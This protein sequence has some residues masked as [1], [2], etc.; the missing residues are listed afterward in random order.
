MTSDTYA[1]PETYPERAEL[2]RDLKA[3]ARQ[4]LGRSSENQEWELVDRSPLRTIHVLYSMADGS[5]VD[6]P[7]YM[8][9]DALNRRLSTGG[10]A[11]TSRRDRAPAYL[12]G[13]TLCFKHPDAAE[14]TI[15][16][17]LGILSDCNAS[18]LRNDNS[19]RIHA[20]NR[21][22]QSWRALQDHLTRQRE[23]EQ[24]EQQRL[25]VEATLRLAE[26]ASGRKK[27]SD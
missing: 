5:R 26:A 7:E 11:F 15:L 14:A 13:K 21:H 17:D 27:A 16:R 10:P 1:I 4:M 6:V 18:E 9:E 12:Q 8:V 23:E 3:E 2:A 20:E 25:Q 19:K 24:R 22:K